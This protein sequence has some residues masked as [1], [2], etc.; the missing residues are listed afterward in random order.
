MEGP[1]SDRG[2]WRGRF[3]HGCVLGVWNGPRWCLHRRGG[4]GVETGVPAGRRGK[5]GL[6]EQL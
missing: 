6:F 2:H 5:Q 4:R 3:V 1:L